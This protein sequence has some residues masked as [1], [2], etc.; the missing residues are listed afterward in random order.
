MFGITKSMKQKAERTVYSRISHINTSQVAFT[1]NMCE[2]KY[3]IFHVA[4]VLL[5]RRIC[6]RHIPPGRLN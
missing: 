3:T 5:I 2:G 4:N 6:K 1:M